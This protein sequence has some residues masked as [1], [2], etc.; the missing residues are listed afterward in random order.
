VTVEKIAESG[1]IRPLALKGLNHRSLD[2]ALEGPLF[3]GGVGFFAHFRKVLNTKG[4]LDRVLH[5]V[6]IAAN[7]AVEERRFQRRVRA[8]S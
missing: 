6:V 3:H 5:C 1:A 8:S 7:V 2:P 4:L